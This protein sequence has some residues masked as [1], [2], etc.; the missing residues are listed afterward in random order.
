[1]STPLQIPASRLEQ[2]DLILIN[3]KEARVI[4]TYNPMFTEGLEITFM[5]DTVAGIEKTVVADDDM[6]TVLDMSRG[7]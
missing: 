6:I 7:K 3:D 4:R 2:N 1:M 5:S